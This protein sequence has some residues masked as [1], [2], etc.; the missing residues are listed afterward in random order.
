M[1]KE[2]FSQM[3]VFDQCNLVIKSPYLF[4]SKRLSVDGRPVDGHYSVYNCY[5]MLGCVHV[6]G[7]RVVGV[8]LIER[9]DTKVIERFMPSFWDLY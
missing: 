1:N 8:Y 9:N 6:S 5:P 4:T 7:N 2:Q 3:G